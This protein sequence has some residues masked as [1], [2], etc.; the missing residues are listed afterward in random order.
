[1]FWT[2]LV[3]FLHKILMPNVR[4]IRDRVIILHSNAPSHIDTS[5]YCFS[6][7]WL[8]S[9]QPSEYDLI[10]KLKDRLQST[11]QNRS[12]GIHFESRV[13]FL[14]VLLICTYSVKS[15]RHSIS[16]TKFWYTL[17]HL[18]LSTLFLLIPKILKTFKT[19][20]FTQNRPLMV[21]STSSPS[22]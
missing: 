17:F 14:V 9:A 8:G 22:P 20:K 21:L 13:N 18:V 7:I 19:K 1:M 6:G 12:F 15:S 2:N 3:Q 4:Q 11:Y 5:V 10:P 16:I